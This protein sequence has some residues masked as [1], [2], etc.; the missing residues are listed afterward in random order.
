MCT[1][2]VLIPGW[3]LELLH[4]KRPSCRLEPSRGCMRVGRG[5][6]AAWALGSAW[7]E[8][9]ADRCPSVSCRR[10]PTVLP[11]AV[12]PR[13]LCRRPS[14][15]VC[16]RLLTQTP[17]L[18]PRRPPRVNIHWAPAVGQGHEATWVSVASTLQLAFLWALGSWPRVQWVPFIPSRPQTRCRTT[19]AGESCGGQRP[20]A[21]CAGSSWGLG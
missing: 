1:S 3:A 5:C 17:L 13:P 8:R 18:P 10:A 19:A 20:P 12:T 14:G 2:G 15:L 21:L 9:L 7:G 16:L 4:S 11:G 6:V